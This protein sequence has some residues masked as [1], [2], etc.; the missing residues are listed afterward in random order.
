MPLSSWWA[1]GG[2]GEGGEARCAL[3]RTGGFSSL[4]N[5]RRC[6]ADWT[7]QPAPTEQVMPKPS[8]QRHVAKRSTAQCL[9]RP[10]L[11]SSLGT[12][13]RTVAREHVEL[14]RGTAA[15]F[16]GHPGGL[17]AEAGSSPRRPQIVTIHQEPFVYVKPTLSDGTC[18]EEFT[19][20]GDPVKKVICT[21]PNDTSP[22]SRECGSR[23]TWV[24]RGRAA[25][26]RW[27]GPICLPSTPH[28]ATVLLRLLH[29]P[30]H[31]AGEDHELHLRGAPG[32]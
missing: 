26:A 23:G 5:Q 20:N 25:R 30:A 31:Q 17:G 12:L 16:G 32:G 21:G 15:G 14:S 18:K 22:G 27:S 7:F 3:C 10:Q 8:P 2:G 4:S 9:R 13:L 11:P 28:S 6:W 1:A 29:R 19:V 24:R